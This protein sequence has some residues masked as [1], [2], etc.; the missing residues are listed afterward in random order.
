RTVTEETIAFHALCE[1]LA[2]LELRGL[3]PAG[4]EERIWQNTLTALVTGLNDAA[5]ARAETRSRTR[6]AR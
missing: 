1:G 3:L 4:E 6:S 5:R 2:A